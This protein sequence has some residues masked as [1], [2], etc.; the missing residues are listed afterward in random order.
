MRQY[1]TVPCSIVHWSLLSIIWMISGWLLNWLETS[2]T[3]D[4]NR[5][6]SSHHL[7]IMGLGNVVSL[8]TR[9]IDKNLCN[10]LAPTV[11]LTSY[12]PVEC[13]HLYIGFYIYTLYDV[14]KR[15]LI[16]GYRIVMS[17]ESTVHLTGTM[18]EILTYFAIV[19]ILSL[20]ID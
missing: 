11:M 9:L 16:S 5:T 3:C 20:C 13:S 15:L 2:T 19:Y 8:L 1:V 17:Q 14:F 4:W 18:N 7:Y 12:L 6:N 10:N